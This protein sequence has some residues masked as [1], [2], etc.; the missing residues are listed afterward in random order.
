MHVPLPGWAVNVGAGHAHVLTPV[1][2][3]LAQGLAHN[4]CSIIIKETNYNTCDDFPFLTKKLM[5]SQLHFTILGN[6][7]L[8]Q[9]PGPELH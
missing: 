1:S 6:E 8:P 9:R 4:S 2:T 5:V 7:A 3:Y